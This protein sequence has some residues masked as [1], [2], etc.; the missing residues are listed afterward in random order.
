MSTELCYLPEKLREIRFQP[1]INLWTFKVA[2]S[3]PLITQ[4]NVGNLSSVKLIKNNLRGFFEYCSFLLNTDIQV[5]LIKYL[6]QPVYLLHDIMCF[7]SSCVFQVFT[8]IER[9][10]LSGMCWHTLTT[11]WSNNFNRVTLLQIQLTVQN[12][13]S[14]RFWTIWSTNLVV[15]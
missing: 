14:I 6:K 4:W 9:P 5:F 7:N 2:Y 10:A 13:A 11:V 12:T 3:D 15:T 1:E 8:T